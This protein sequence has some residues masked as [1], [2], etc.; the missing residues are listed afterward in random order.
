MNKLIQF[1]AELTT[2][3]TYATKPN[4]Q[5]SF[6]LQEALEPQHI[7]Q[8]LS[9]KGQTGWLVF[10]PTQTQ[11]RPEDIPEIPVEPNLGKTPTQ[12][13][14]SVLFVYFKHLQTEK[15]LKDDVNFNHWRE[16]YMEK[17]IDM[18]KAKLPE[19]N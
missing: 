12:R 1:P 13:L 3:K 15:I 8:L 19:Q 7:A 9:A 6:E 5:V 18:V 17:I 11:V 16:D 4:V 10:S 2:Y 14:Y